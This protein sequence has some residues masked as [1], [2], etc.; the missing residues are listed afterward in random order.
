MEKLNFFNKYKERKP[1]QTISIIKDFF[2][3]RNYVILEK[4]IEQAEDSLT[5]SCHLLLYYNDIFITFSNGKGLNKEYCL[6]SGYA[7]LFE[8]FCN[9]LHLYLN[10]IMYKKYRELN[11]NKEKKLLSFQ[12]IYENESIKQFYSCFSNNE[13]LIEQYFLGICNNEFIGEKYKNCF[14]DNIKYFEPRILYH[15][16]TSTGMASGNSLEEALVQGISEFF[17]RYVSDEFYSNPNLI[18]YKLNLNEIKIE[19]SLKDIIN[20]IEQNYQIDFF[21][22][23]YNFDFPVILGILKNKESFCFAPSFG[24]FPDFNIALERVITELYQGIYNYKYFNY[25]SI[26][27]PY[28]LYPWSYW[29]IKYEGSY[30]SC[31]AIPENIFLNNQTVN[32][33]NK[34]IF[35]EKKS[36]I[37][38]LEYYKKI[39][40]QKNINLY[41]KNNSL[42]KDMYSLHIFSDN[43]LPLKNNCSYIFSKQEKESILIYVI[44]KYRMINYLVNKNNSLFLKEYNEFMC[45]KEIYDGFQIDKV[46]ERAEIYSPYPLSRLGIDLGLEEINNN[47]YLNIL[48]ILSDTFFTPFIKKYLILKNYKNNNYLLQDINKIF[49]SNFT[50]EDYNN[51]NNN[52]YFLNKIFFEP[53]YKEYYSQNYKNF[54]KTFIE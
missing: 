45:V 18:Y 4:K 26:Q 42:L 44:N 50:Q 53:I 8:R 47:N 3:N 10:P 11:I 21:D 40:T 30:Q 9:K 22:L 13:N 23:S 38:F 16:L 36:N 43:L 6:A 15:M 37:D 1:L 25:N 19:Q 32:T 14:N 27:E 49:N 31:P 2:K 5:W 46:L 29:R 39:C 24:C 17:E 12:D 20:L 7:E 33:Y 54:I 51:I 41:Y 34:K 35:I 28:T 48:G 52:A